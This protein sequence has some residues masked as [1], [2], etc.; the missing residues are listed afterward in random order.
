MSRAASRRPAESYAGKRAARKPS[1]RAAR[2]HV[3]A[4]QPA[5]QP[6][7]QPTEQ[8]VEQPPQRPA[9]QPA[10][11]SAA[12]AA[13]ATEQPTGSP[14]TTTSRRARH[15]LGVTAWLLVVL[16][17]AATLVA[18][19]A[20]Y[21]DDRLADVGAV[22]A[23]TAY[24]WGFAART[25]GRPVVFSVLTLVLGVVV[26]AVDDDTL[27]SGAAVVTAVLTAIFAVMATVPAVN[28][29]GAIRENVVALLL[30]SVG[31]MA[32]LAWSPVVDLHR[33]EYTVLGLSLLG[34]FLSV[35][36]LG[37]GLHGLGTRGVL[38][39]VGGGIMLA[40]TLGYAEL[41][42]R[43]GS[44]DVVA[45]LDDAVR[46]SHHHLGA[47]PR[48][49][50]AFLGIPALTWGTHMRARRR[51]GWW[52][53]AFGVALTAPVAY[54]L[55]DPGR[56][57]VSV[58]LATAYGAVIGLVLGFL[59]IRVDLALTGPR[60]RRLATSEQAPAVRPEPGRTH[61]LW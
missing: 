22:A 38:T 56:S 31:A 55:V 24:A 15:A 46:W 11:R 59:L 10:G 57:V 41:L 2:A 26:V 21:V 49:I 23:S 37:A 54:S 18:S 7:H 29:L 45:S 12:E 25:G 27:R 9:E 32:T 43:Y 47:F 53:C 48:P 33:F 51:Q 61:P 58:V 28:L 39:V 19:L 3:P 8:P 16:G 17:A 20:G 44:H 52:V 36:R 5:H 30:A 34:A 50:I 13:E 40:L 35:Y 14:A 42:Q 4:E 1:R 6:A 60:G